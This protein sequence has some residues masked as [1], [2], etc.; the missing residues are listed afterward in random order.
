M[1]EFIIEVARVGAV[2]KHPNA[3][4]LSLAEVSGY[5]VIFRTG[6]YNEGDLAVYVPVDAIVPEND[7][8]WEFLK[9]ARRI[10]AKRLRDIYSQGILTAADPKWPEGFD[11]RE[12][13]GIT[14][15]EPAMGGGSNGPNRMRESG[16]DTESAPAP[17][18]VPLYTDI[19][20]YRRHKNV[21]QIGESVSLGEKVHGANARY[22]WDGEQFHVGSRTQWK[23]ESETNQWWVCAVRAG[24]KEKLQNVPGI[25][26]YGEV[27]GQVQDL[28]YGAG[29]GDVFFRAF[30]AWHVRELRYLNHGEFVALMA[31]IEIPTVPYLYVGPW[32][33]E[34]LLE[35]RNGPSTVPGA[36]N[37]REGFVV[38]PLIERREHMGRVCLKL[39]GEGYLL[40]KGA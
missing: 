10:K 22:Y 6:E 32:D 15:Y 12:A 1:S 28:K 5:P 40:R 7:P 36:S 23:R 19:E 4:T 13:L 34:V 18:G 3:D 14:K 33:P 9:G 37:I 11:A 39:V 20:S 31:E 25:A 38:K 2:S 30:D 16:P 8:R 35:L 17:S 29:K 27:F 26:V 21:L 24:L